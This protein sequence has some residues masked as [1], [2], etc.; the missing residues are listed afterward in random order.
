MAETALTR[1]T[2]AGKWSATGV[3]MTMT[4]I[5]NTN[6]NSF[7]SAQD[8]IVLVHNPTGGP[9][10]FGMT[11][12]PLRGTGRSGDVSQSIAAGEIRAF[13]VTQDGWEDSN[14]N[15][16]IPTG[17]SASLKVGILTLG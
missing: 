16:L 10:T 7:T 15:I 13:R 11:S 12:Q 2:A 1:T 17:I 4:A 14:G 9:L 8:Q 6:G 5:D 3:A